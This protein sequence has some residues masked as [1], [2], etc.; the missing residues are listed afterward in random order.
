MATIT[1]GV[2]ANGKRQRRTVYGKTKTEAQEKLTRLQ[3]SKLGGLLNAVNKATLGEHLNRWLAH[4][5][6]TS[7]RTTTYHAYE[8]AV[9]LH[10][11]PLIGGVR[12][13]KLTADHLRGLYAELGNQAVG[14]TTVRKVHAVL[15]RALKQ[16]VRDGL[17][18]RN[19]CDAVVAPRVPDP[20]IHPLDAA[21]AATLLEAAKTFRGGR[22]YPIMATALGTGM[23]L[24][25]L[26]GLSW[27]DVDLDGGTIHVRFTLEEA[28]G[29]L[30]RRE[31]KTA[32]ARRKID[33]P[34]F[35]VEVLWQQKRSQLAAGL[36]AC[37]LV[38]PT[39]TGKPQH[40]ATFHAKH[41]KPLLAEA[42]L[43][44]IRFHDLRHSSATLLLSQGVHPKVVQERLGHSQI[45]ITL[46]TYS[47]V[48]PGLQEEA[49]RRLND[50]FTAPAAAPK[51][52][53]P[54]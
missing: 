47:H 13:E 17:I 19:P 7:L 51:K 14:A 38:F 6:R 18:P 16:A 52:A 29:K 40:R 41:Y 32:K 53:A 8:S 45:S 20:E 31:P 39:S 46:D 22:T 12:L 10:I 54:G 23:R 43:P 33:L 2:D 30:T 24:G 26:L 44:P 36:A 34:T 9:R 50:V 21:Q 27:D 3:S 28:G 49:A 4:T 5:V 42:G 48:L 15:R 35:V 25:E 1:V 11:S 37:D